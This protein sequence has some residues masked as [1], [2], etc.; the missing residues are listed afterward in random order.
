MHVRTTALATIAVLAATLTACSSDKP[1]SK[2]SHTAGDS[3]SVA[4]Q[5]S[6]ARATVRLVW[7]HTGKDVAGTT[8]LTYVA[9]VSNPGSSVASVA[10]DAR[11]LDKTGAIV[12]SAEETLPN[13]SAH[14][15]FD[16]L[17]TLGGSLTQFTGTPAKID[18]T[19]AKDAF[20]MA[21]SVEQPMLVTSELKLTQGS[22]DDL[23]TDDPYAYNLTVKVT[24]STHDELKGMVTQ[25]VILY[26]AAGQVVGGDTGTSDNAPDNLPAGMTYREQWT[27]IPAAGKATRA[28]YTVWGG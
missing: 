24:N 8:A 3:A 4:N 26:N 20:G 9:R 22:R 13:I 12:G 25:Q 1:D 6:P 7:S 16:F 10:I 5:S 2:P 11:A 17:G 21:G 27:G 19:Q 14:T 15:T 23:F 18:V 28:I